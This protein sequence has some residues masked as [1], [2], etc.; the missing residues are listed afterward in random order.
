MVGR[1]GRRKLEIFAEQVQTEA[2]KKLVISN[3]QGGLFKSFVETFL[4]EPMGKGTVVRASFE[5]ELS[6]GYVGKVFN[7][8]VLERTVRDNLAMYTRNLRDF[9]ELLPVPEREIGSAPEGR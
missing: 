5:Y 6:M 8:L 4:T 9:S 1:A 2:K 3:G 7:V